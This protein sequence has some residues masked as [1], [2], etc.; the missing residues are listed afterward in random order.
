MTIEVESGK[1]PHHPPVTIL[2]VDDEPAIRE[3]LKLLFERDGYHCLTSENGH[4]A[5]KTLDSIKVDVVVTDINMP[6]MSGV[7]LLRQGKKLT[8]SDFIVITGY[9]DDFTY[10]NLIE[11]GASD[12]IYKPITSKE[13]LIRLKRV[14][15]ERFLLIERDRIHDELEESNIQLKK[16]A[17]ELRETLTE[18]KNAHDELR[19]AY[20]DTINR[21]VIAAEFKDEDT[22]DHIMRISLFSTLVAE[23]IGLPAE[24]ISNIRYAAPMH[25]IGKIGIP[26]RILLKSEILTPEEF[27]IIKTHTSIGASILSGSR[28]D[29]LRMAHDIALTH[30]EKW[31][32]TGYPN[33]IKGEKIP[34]TGRIVGLV[35]VFDALTSHRP[36]KKP[37]PIDIACDII[38]KE[39]EHQFDPMVVD[40]FINQMNEIK[41]IKKDFGAMHQIKLSDFQW[42]ERDIQAGMDKKFAKENK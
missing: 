1:A 27:E 35:D 23:K 4:E 34:I 14:L 25:D 41:T 29:V 40:A 36:Y 7:E 19:E 39:R 13:M 6:G 10:D 37:Y 8:R 33:G 22:G 21:L 11:E 16:Y 32:G 12:F 31:N 15:R 17:N 28:S 38:L 26:D 30:H 5:L 18:L 3:M 42:S 9:V 20:L 2:V 24:L